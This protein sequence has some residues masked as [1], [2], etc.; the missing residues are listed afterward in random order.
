MPA[1]GQATEQQLLG[2][3]LLDVV[4]DHAGHRPRTHLHIVATLGKPRA[5]FRLDHELDATGFELGLELEHELV[6]DALDNLA[7]QRLELDD[8]IQTVAEFRREAAPDGLHAIGTAVARIETDTTAGHGF[9]TG[10]GRH[11]QDHVAEIGF[12]TVVVGELAVVHDLQQ[13]IEDI[14]M[15]LLDLVEQY[16]RMRLFGHRLGEQ[17]ALVVTDIAGR[18]TDQTRDGMPL[19]VLGHIETDQL[20]AEMQRQL[21]RDLGLADTG[22]AGEQEGAD[23]LVA[24]IQA[25]TRHLDRARE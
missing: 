19:H 20:D 1:V 10:V 9:R 12:A 15:R 25:R 23:R 4:L 2:Q 7:L 5:G 6:D 18:R 22:R 17:T 14:R 3:R 24:I 21:T 11:H 16:H 8:R 13:Q